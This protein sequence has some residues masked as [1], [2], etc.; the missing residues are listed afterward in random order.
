M[1]NGTLLPCSCCERGVHTVKADADLQALIV[2]RRAYGTIHTGV[3]SLS[4][5][6]GLLDPHGTSFT[7][8]RR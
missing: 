3:Y 4:D 5:I 6:V 7:A 2:R 8:V 1:G